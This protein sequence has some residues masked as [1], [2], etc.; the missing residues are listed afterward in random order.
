MQQCDILCHKGR[1]LL[2]I[3]CPN[4]SLIF[5]LKHSVCLQKLTF[6][7]EVCRTL[8]ELSVLSRQF[9]FLIGFDLF[10]NKNT[11]VFQRHIIPSRMG[12]ME[13]L[14][15][16]GKQ[17]HTRA[18]TPMCTRARV[19]VERTKPNL[20][21]A[22]YW[23]ADVFIVKTS[24]LKVGVTSEGTQNSSLSW[25]VIIWTLLERKWS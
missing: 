15:P 20:C 2:R 23:T 11:A 24:P 12:V 1:S 16:H 17:S 8:V 10:V 4:Q 18:H 19:F 14:F 9:S 5:E 25:S 6:M 7:F 13:R 22:S 3:T 21:L